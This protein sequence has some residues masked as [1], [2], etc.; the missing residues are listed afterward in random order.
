MTTIRTKLKGY[1]IFKL[2]QSLKYVPLSICSKQI[3][4]KN[5][6]R[7]MDK[8]KVSATNYY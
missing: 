7:K 3:N 1:L 5:S 4:L 2:L 8:N 6:C